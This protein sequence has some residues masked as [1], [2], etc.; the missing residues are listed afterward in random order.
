MSSCHAISDQ[1]PSITVYFFKSPVLWIESGKARS[2]F[3]GT[4]FWMPRGTFES[5]P[6]SLACVTEVP[7]SWTW[8]LLDV[9]M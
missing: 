9:V 2:S 6:P 3:S 8:R 4:A 5:A 1:V 7:V